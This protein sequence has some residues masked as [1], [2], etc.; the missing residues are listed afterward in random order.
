[1]RRREPDDQISGCRGEAESSQKRI[2]H[3]FS[4]YKNPFTGSAWQLREWKERQKLTDIYE[5]PDNGN[6]SQQRFPQPPISLW[7]AALP[8]VK[9][10][11]TDTLDSQLNPVSTNL[12]PSAENL[13]HSSPRKSDTTQAA[14]SPGVSAT[15]TGTVSGFPNPAMPARVDTAGVPIAMASRSLLCMPTRCRSGHT[16]TAAR[17]R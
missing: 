13:S 16:L 5:R 14:N 17:A 2:D 3:D 11:S 8:A 12:R 15:L 10:S 4:R 1:M 6:K 9:R 7:T